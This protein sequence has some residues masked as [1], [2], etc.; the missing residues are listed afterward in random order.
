MWHFDKSFF[1]VNLSMCN[2]LP[3]HCSK[4]FKKQV[5]YIG[6]FWNP[7]DIMIVSYLF[8]VYIVLIYKGKGWIEQSTFMQKHKFDGNNR[9][10]FFYTFIRALNSE[11]YVLFDS[12]LCHL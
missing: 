7:S 12:D 2:A 5:E 8:I 11:Y 6:G 10:S 1:K 4:S 9:P 3:W